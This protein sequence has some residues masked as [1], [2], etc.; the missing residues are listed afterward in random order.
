MKCPKCQNEINIYKGVAC[1]SCGYNVLS[2]PTETENQASSTDEHVEKPKQKKAKPK[3]EERSILGWYA[4]CWAECGN[5]SGRARRMEYWSFQLVN[6]LLLVPIFSLGWIFFDVKTAL[7]ASLVYL[8]LSAVP[9]IAVTIRRLHDSGKSGVIL[10]CFIVI[11]IAISFLPLFILPF[12]PIIASLLC[13]FV[14][15]VFMFEDSRRGVN[16]WGDSPRYPSG[17][18]VRRF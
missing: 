12:L 9:N 5:F 8:V 18:Y 10:L 16:K 2:R 13:M 3:P 15:L 14:I 7:I 17:V 11:Q 6:F 1:N 4:K